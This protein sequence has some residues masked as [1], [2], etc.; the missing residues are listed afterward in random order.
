MPT[1]TYKVT[2]RLSIVIEVDADSRHLA[3]DGA[4]SKVHNALHRAG[5]QKVICTEWLARPIRPAEGR[6]EA[7]K[8]RG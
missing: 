4:S 2:L 1:N 7:T 6:P 8:K 3:F 5:A